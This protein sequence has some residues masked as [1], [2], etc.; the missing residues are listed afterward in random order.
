MEIQD[1]LFNKLLHLS[2][3]EQEKVLDEIGFDVMYDADEYCGKLI[4][5]TAWLDPDPDVL[6]AFFEST[7][8][9]PI[10]RM[11][12]YSHSKSLSKKER[13]AYREYLIEAALEDEYHPG[14]FVGTLSC[15]QKKL[16]VI[17]ERT[18]GGWDCEA[19]LAGVF[20]TWS[21]AV[22]ELGGPRGQ[23]I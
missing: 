17:A 19:K 8:D 2:V 14:L 10:N 22:K 21:D 13:N 7:L 12:Q 4:D 9:D 1:N 16:L 18:G 3:T 15:G 20:A 11:D 6:L 23:E 5:A